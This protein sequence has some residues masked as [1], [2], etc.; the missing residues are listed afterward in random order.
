MTSVG[1]V[2]INDGSCVLRGDFCVVM[3]EPS[4]LT[5]YFYSFVG[6]QTTMM[7]WRLA[8]WTTKKVSSICT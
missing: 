6:A 5:F 7:T 2:L 8:S 1:C 3:A 4:L